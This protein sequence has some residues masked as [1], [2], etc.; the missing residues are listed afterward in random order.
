MKRAVLC[1]MFSVMLMLPLAAFGRLIDL[2]YGWEPTEVQVTPE[3]DYD[4]VGVGGSVFTTGSLGTLYEVHGLP[5]GYEVKSAIEWCA[6]CGR[7]SAADSGWVVGSA[8]RCR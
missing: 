7:K 2:H 1:L 8:T 4:H 6:R 3:G 5:A